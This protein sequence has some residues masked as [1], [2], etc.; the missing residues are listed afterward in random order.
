MKMMLGDAQ[1]IARV[2]EKASA[3]AKRQPGSERRHIRTISD[4]ELA[5]LSMQAIARLEGVTASGTTIR[6]RV[7]RGEM[8]LREAALTPPLAAKPPKPSLSQKRRFFGLER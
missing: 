4:E 7:E 6:K 8:S 3:K 2:K 5:T 1:Q